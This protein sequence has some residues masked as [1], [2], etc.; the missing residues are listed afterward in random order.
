MTAAEKRAKIQGRFREVFNHV[1]KAEKGSTRRI[2]A[3]VDDMFDD[4]PFT[5]DEPATPPPPA[6]WRDGLS[7]RWSRGV[8]CSL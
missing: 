4:I 6:D 8:E 3:L 5:D 2:V 7:G 1:L